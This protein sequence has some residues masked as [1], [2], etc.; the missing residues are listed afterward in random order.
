MSIINTG[1]IYSHYKRPNK[2][3]EILGIAKNSNNLTEMVIY[4]ALYQGEF[5]FG[6]IWVRPLEEFLE[7]IEFNGKKIQ[8]FN[9]IEE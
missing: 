4:K 1:D 3:Y 9:K 2:R 8:R 5:K 6:T 7:T